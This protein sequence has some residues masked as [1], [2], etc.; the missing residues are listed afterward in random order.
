MTWHDRL[1]WRAQLRGSRTALV[2]KYVVAKL[3]DCSDQSGA[4]DQSS[5]V[6]HIWPVGAGIS[7]E[8]TDPVVMG[9]T[10]RL[11]HLQ[12]SLANPVQ[13]DVVVA[14]LHH[15][16]RLHHVLLVSRSVEKHL[17][18][19]LGENLGGFLWPNNPQPTTYKVQTSELVGNSNDS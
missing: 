1:V 9:Q 8:L 6:T 12:L 11:V 17:G 13:P 2:A 10:Q 5:L 14:A 7:S 19:L 4:P 16:L 15:G 3:V 18:P